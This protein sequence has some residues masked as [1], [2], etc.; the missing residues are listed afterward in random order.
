MT[1]KRILILFGILVLIIVIFVFSR[2]YLL[3]HSFSFP[4]LAGQTVTID[5]HTFHVSVAK[6]EQ[7]KEAGLSERQALSADEGMLFTFGTPDYYRFWM[8]NMKFPID[9]IYIQANKIVTIHA[10][11]QPPQTGKDTLPIYTSSQPANI[12]LEINAGL[13]QKYNFQN[14]DTVTVSH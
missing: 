6:T 10:N 3:T 14:G 1:F 11:V 8:R 9:I 12:V 7:E 2:A 13:S 5:G 4:S